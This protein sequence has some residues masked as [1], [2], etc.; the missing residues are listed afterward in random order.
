MKTKTEIFIDKVKAKNHANHKD[1]NGKSLYSYEKAVYTL[2][3]KK[4]VVTCSLHGDFEQTASKHLLGAGCSVCVRVR[5]N[6]KLRGNLDD[7][8]KRANKK[9][10]NKYDYSKSVYKN[11]DT[12]II[13]SCSI[14]GDFEQVPNSHLQGNGCAKCASVGRGVK[15][16]STSSEFIKKASVKHNNKYDYS[17]VNY[18]NNYTK[19]SITCLEH[20]AFKQIPANH[21]KGKGCPTCTKNKK[22]TTEEFIEKAIRIHDTLYDYSEVVYI[23]SEQKIKIICAVHGVFEQSPSLHI[24]QKNGCPKCANALFGWTKTDFINQCIKNNNGLGILYVIR[25]FNDTESFYKVGITSLSIIERYRKTSSLPYD[26]DVIHEIQL[27]P[28]KVYDS[29]ND[30][31]RTFSKYSYKPLLDFAGQTECFSNIEPIQQWLETNLLT[32]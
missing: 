3:N 15:R 4:I 26:Y 20:G 17:E 28:S 2:S 11:S 25:C 22:P 10:S 30:I 1:S 19:I 5:I 12:K 7:F 16:A 32:K 6:D 23:N 29:E 9:H 14:H 31:L 24:N 27:D 8:I 13:I 21:L 18:I